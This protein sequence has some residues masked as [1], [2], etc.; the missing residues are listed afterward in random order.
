MKIVNKKLKIGKYKEMEVFVDWA[1]LQKGRGLRKKEDLL[2]LAFGRFLFVI[3]VIAMTIITIA[4]ISLGNFIVFEAIKNDSQISLV[5]WL[6]L[7]LFLYAS[8]LLR[9]RSKFF[10]TLDLKAL[11]KLAKDIE[12]NNSP[13]EVEILDFVDYD[14]LNTL[15]KLLENNQENIY[16][17]LMIDL[18]ELQDVGQLINRLGIQKEILLNEIGQL[19]MTIEGDK[20]YQINKLLY[21]SFVMGLD[22]KFSFIGE[23]I[24]FLKL[25]L[26]EYNQVFMKLGITKGTLLSVLE[27][28]KAQAMGNRYRKLWKY[29]ASLKPRSTVNRSYT[30]AHTPTL[31]KYSRDLTRE[32]IDGEFSYALSRETEIADVIRYLKPEKGAVLL[33]GEAGVGKTTILKSIAVKM[34]VEDVP[35]NLKDKRLVEFDFHRAVTQALDTSKLRALIEDIIV[36]VGK[37]K[38]VVL[39]IDDLDELI[40][41]KDDISDEIV[42][43]LHKALSNN[44]ISLVATSSNEG[45]I[46]SIKPNTQLANIFD[47]VRI[48]EPSPEIAL[49]IIFDERSKLE[50]MYNIKIQFDALK[51]AIELTDRYDKTRVFPFKAID[52]LEDAC[53]LALEEGLGFVSAS[54]V[55]AVVSKDAGIKVGRLDET[56]GQK[57]LQLEDRMKRRVIGQDN[58]IKAVVSALK[59]ARAG[60]VSKNKPLSSFL[61]FGPTGVGKTEV[62]RTLAAVYFGDE[63]LITRIDMSEFQEEKNV[64]RLIGSSDEDGFVGGQLTEKV[65]EHPFSLILL[66]EIEK[67]NPKVLDLFLQVLDEGHIKDGLGRVVD[68][69]NTIIIATSNIGSKSIA[70]SFSKE[71]SY[72]KTERMAK[73]EL[74]KY[75]RIEFINRFDKVIMFKPLSKIEIEKIAGLMMNQVVDRLKEQGIGLKFE[76]QLL[77][78]LAQKG[79]SL[80]YGAREMRRVI[81]DEVETRIADMIVAGKLKSGDTLTIKSLEEFEV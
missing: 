10:D 39:V 71:I 54:Q 15:D 55:E 57:L 81:Q 41:L 68:F 73:E 19:D 43:T 52:T 42:S 44:S 26:D 7:A 61:F 1:Y 24:I 13:K 62:A 37:S 4:Q 36:E 53:V 56:E 49:Q 6:V 47:V 74:K 50:D 60:L 21:Q 18:L 48:D 33:L 63:K 8:Y 58:A 31:N 75:L 9:D 40:G 65:R 11:T 16:E 67:A 76:A 23:W 2:Q 70:D 30:S 5:F 77:S 66:D 78:Q 34:V 64:S 72:E 32:V 3:A 45:Y 35:S 38:N 28:T 27:W 29:K 46:K 22:Y 80:M 79:Y 69:K 59:R 17:N 12:D 20:V 51:S 14:V 25:A